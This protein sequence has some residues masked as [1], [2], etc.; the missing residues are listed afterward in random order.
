MSILLNPYLSFAADARQAMEF[1]AAVLG[2]TLTITTFGE[3]GDADAPHAH[4]VMHA[5][6]DSMQGI[7]LMAS[8]TPPGMEHHPGT[9]VSLSLSGEDEDTLR[10]YWDGLC[11]GG[12]AVMPLA[13]Q[14]WGALFGMV[15]DQFGIAW[16]VNI[17]HP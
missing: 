17:T 4:L 6:L 9:N 10:G 3:S 7:T 1:Y 2:G 13:E 16:M 14:P 15:T 8:D 12:T 5:R 11:I